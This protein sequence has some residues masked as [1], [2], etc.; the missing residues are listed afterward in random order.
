MAEVAT[1]LKR[2]QQEIID[3]I[4]HTK[5]SDIFGVIK[6]DLSAFLTFEN[7][8]QFLKEGVTAEQWKSQFS[9][10][11]IQE[12]KD[13]MEFAWEKANDQRGLSSARAIMHMES[14]LWLAGEDEFL[15]FAQD[16]DN[17]YAPYGKPI[18]AAICKKYGIRNQDNGDKS[19]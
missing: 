14:W 1:T 16:E 13:Y 19:V 8:K 6:S 15:K 2:T 9:S 17:N 12:I 10:D 18:L 7:V 11:P 5:E 4:R 3:R